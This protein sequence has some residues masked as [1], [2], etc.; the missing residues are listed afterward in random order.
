MKRHLCALG[1][2]AGWFI[3]RARGF[4]ATTICVD[5]P[6][7]GGCD[8]LNS[9]FGI[10][11]PGMYYAFVAMEAGAVYLSVTAISAIFRRVFKEPERD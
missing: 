11:G 10:V 7:V 9:W 3:T 5:G 4:G 1:L 2:S 8:F 6:T